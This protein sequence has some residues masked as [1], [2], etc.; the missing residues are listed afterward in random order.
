MKTIKRILAIFLLVVTV[1][2]V[3]YFVFT[4]NRQTIGLTIQNIAYVRWFYG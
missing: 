1:V 3:G 2:I 4:A